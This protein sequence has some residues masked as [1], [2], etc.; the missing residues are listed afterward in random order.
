MGNSANYSFNPNPSGIQNSVYPLG[1]IARAEADISQISAVIN[2][3]IT[4]CVMINVDEAEKLL[5]KGIDSAYF[6]PNKQIITTSTIDDRWLPKYYLEKEADIVMKFGPSHHVPRDRP[7]Y[8]SQNKKERLWNIQTQV[9]DTLQMKEILAD[10]KINMIPLLK[11]VDMEELLSSYVPLKNEGFQAFSYYS[12]QYFGNGRGNLT[13]E[14]IKDMRTVANLPELDYVML[15]GTQSD[16]I[17]RKL[18]SIVK[19]YAGMRFV[20]ENCW[21]QPG[22]TKRGQSQLSQ[23][24]VGE[25]KKSTGVMSD[26]LALKKEDSTS[27]G[28]K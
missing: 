18:P 8:L 23:Y 2:S 5:R 6:G 20:K 9:E 16:N 26:V 4:K 24:Y 12:A 22:F 25:P 28:G 10:S 7:V 1:H 15:I 3:T 17:I 14:L 11:G 13:S 27:P 19:A 21:Q